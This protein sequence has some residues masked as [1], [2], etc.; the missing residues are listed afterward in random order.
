[1]LRLSTLAFQLEQSPGIGRRAAEAAFEA[2]ARADAFLTDSDL[3]LWSDVR[4]VTPRDEFGEPDR[5]TEDRGGG[6]R[7]QAFTRPSGL[8]D[9]ARDLDGR[10]DD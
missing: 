6:A 9:G 5:A 2:G 8:L 1:M 7:L 4:I 3:W 10:D